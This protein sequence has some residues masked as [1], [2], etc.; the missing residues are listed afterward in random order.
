MYNDI[1]GMKL[2]KN[3]CRKYDTYNIYEDYNIEVYL[4]IRA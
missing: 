4:E 3:N 1:F 2:I